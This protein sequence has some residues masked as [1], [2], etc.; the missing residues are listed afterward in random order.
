VWAA[1][2]PESEVSGGSISFLNMTHIGI[3]RRTERE[4]GIV[5]SNT[6][7]SKYALA[8]NAETASYKKTAQANLQSNA[9][10][11]LLLPTTCPD[12]SESSC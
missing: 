8:V 2:V 6:Q 11:V 5:V 7:F 3:Y 4:S 12:L 9:E 1:N 10:Y